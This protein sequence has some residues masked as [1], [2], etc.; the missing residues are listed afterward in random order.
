MSRTLAH[1]REEGAV[2]LDQVVRHLLEE[3]H[4]PVARPEDHLAHDALAVLVQA[5][6]HVVA[7]GMV[8]ARDPQVVR[9]ERLVDDARVGAL[10]ERVHQRG[11]DVARPRPEVDAQRAHRGGG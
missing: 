7:A 8:G 10:R 1:A 6:Q 11:R 2:E 5:A 9:V 4:R 3:D